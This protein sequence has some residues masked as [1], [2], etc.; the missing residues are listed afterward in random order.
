VNTTTATSEKELIHWVDGIECC[1]AEWER[2]YAEFETS[3]EEIAKFQSRYRKFGVDYWPKD[4]RIAELFCGRGNGLVALERLGFTNLMGVDLAPS[5]LKQ[6][7]GPAELFVGDC[8]KLEFED[9]SLDVVAVQGGLHHLPD[10]SSDLAAVFHE[11]SRVL[12]PSGRFLLVEPWLTPF[13]RIVHFLSRRTLVRKLSSKVDALQR[14]IEHEQ[15]I[16][17]AWL[18]RPNEIKELLTARF[19]TEWLT[20][21]FGK[22]QF[23][24]RTSAHS[25]GDVGR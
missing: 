1:D 13:L 5:L 22:L 15:E 10:L 17:D 20:M 16:Y 8:R 9:H 4:N 24:G 11:V 19:E 14:M 6:Y 2:A 21:S 12:I 23:S 3:T 7:S 25:S 18:S